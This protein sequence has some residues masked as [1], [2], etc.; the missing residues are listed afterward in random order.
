LVVSAAQW[1]LDRLSAAATPIEQGRPPRDR[2]LLVWVSD[3]AIAIHHYP[4][5][6]RFDGR[7]WWGGVPGAWIPLT[8]KRWTVTHWMELPK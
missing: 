6:A 7:E 3:R 5:V 4:T 2:E 1:M 8:A